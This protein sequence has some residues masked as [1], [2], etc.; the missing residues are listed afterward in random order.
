MTNAKGM[1]LVE[2]LV[3]VAIIGILGI[4]LGLFLIKYLPDYHLK[5]AVNTLTQDLRQTQIGALKKLSDWKITFDTTNHVYEIRDN[6]NSVVKKVDLKNYESTIRFVDVKDSGGNNLTEIIF[7]EEGMGSKS[8]IIRINNS[9]NTSIN[10][11]ISR[12]GAIRVSP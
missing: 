7:S 11:A 8:T 5:S 12:A 2:L 4:I 3:V 1:S 6:L 10:L 9:K